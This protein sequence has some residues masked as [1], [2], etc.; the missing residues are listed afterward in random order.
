MD[1]PRRRRSAWPGAGIVARHT[2]GSVSRGRTT[3]LRVRVADRAPRRCDPPPRRRP[4]SGAASSL[5][6]SAR[7]RVAA[8]GV[9]HH[10]AVLLTHGLVLELDADD[11]ASTLVHLVR[12]PTP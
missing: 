9:L 5:D 7:Y 11:Y 8:M 1:E 10:G 3:D 6:P 4:V 2:N 12:D